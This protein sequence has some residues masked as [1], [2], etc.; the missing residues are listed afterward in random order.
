MPTD[1]VP[2]CVEHRRDKLW[3]WDQLLASVMFLFVPLHSFFLCF[4][5]EA[6]EGPISTGVCRNSTMLIQITGN[7]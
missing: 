4:L 5:D 3:A 7:I 6:L 2:Q 1:T